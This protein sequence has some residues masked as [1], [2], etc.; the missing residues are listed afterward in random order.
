MLATSS[1]FLSTNPTKK[2]Y[3]ILRLEIMAPNKFFD[4][5]KYYSMIF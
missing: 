5:L 1:L 3:K 4:C 2:I